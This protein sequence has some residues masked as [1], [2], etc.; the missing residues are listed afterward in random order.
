MPDKISQTDPPHGVSHAWRHLSSP[1]LP[2]TPSQ[3]LSQNSYSSPVNSPTLRGKFCQKPFEA[4]PCVAVGRHASQQQ[5]QLFF[6]AKASGPWACG[7]RGNIPEK[8]RRVIRLILRRGGRVAPGASPKTP[9]AVT[10]ALKQN[11]QTAPASLD[12]APSAFPEVRKC[13]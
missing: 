13:G 6:T 7:G 11:L 3:H 4:H 10:L 2:C 8:K 1:A 5:T 12:E 9:T